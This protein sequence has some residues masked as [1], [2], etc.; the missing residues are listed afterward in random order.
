MKTKPTLLALLLLLGGCAGTKLVGTWQNPDF[1]NFRA[2][3][4]LVV[5]MARDK[6]LRMDFEDRFVE[7]FK[8]AG[9]GAMSSTDIF[10]VAFTTAK[11]SEEELEYAMD[12]L[13]GRDFDAILLTKVIGMGHKVTLK[14]SVANLDRAFDSFSNDYLDHQEIYYAD[15]F[16]KEYDLY[17]LETSLYC[18]CEGKERELIW[19]GNIDIV[20]PLDTDKTIETYIALIRES[21]A[22]GEV[23]F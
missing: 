19:R 8:R 11:R 14:E 16:Q 22:D 20:E 12:L 21:M 9:V 3:Q 6:G 4:V 10:D 2:Q 5:G 7:E 23:I 13:V 15:H 17:H 18:I 1:D